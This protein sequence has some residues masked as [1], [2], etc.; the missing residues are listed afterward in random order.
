MKR[1]IMLALSAAVM[2]SLLTGCRNKNMDMDPT[3]EHTSNTTQATHAHTEPATQPHT[4][5]HTHKE[6]HT[7][8]EPGTQDP[9]M[10]DMEITD[11]ADIPG[12][13]VEEGSDIAGRIR[14]HMPR[15]K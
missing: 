8:T 15:M 7:H 11:P 3:V 10:P 13:I 14:R 12:E 2:G 4:E 6:D 9:L 5:D 1:I